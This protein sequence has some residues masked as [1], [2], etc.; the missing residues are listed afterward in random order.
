MANSATI[1]KFGLQTGSDRTLYA[2]WSW[3]KSHTANYEI[4]WTYSTGDG[5]EFVGSSSTTTEKQSTYSIPENAV[6][7]MV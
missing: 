2:T 7:V 6:A 5:G 4:R 3:S 1:T